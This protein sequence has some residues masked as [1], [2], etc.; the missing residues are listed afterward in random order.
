MERRERMLAKLYSL[1]TASRRRHQFVAHGDQIEEPGGG[2]DGPAPVGAGGASCGGPGLQGFIR[3][4][5]QS[6]RPPPRE[7]AL[8]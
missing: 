8:S 2:E 6:Y 4:S 7:S 5:M 1:A 3:D